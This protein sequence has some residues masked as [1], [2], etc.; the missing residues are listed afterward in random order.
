MRSRLCFASLIAGAA[1]VGLLPQQACG[2]GSEFMLAKLIVQ[3]GVV[4]L[5]IT[6]DYGENPMLSGEEDARES[7]QHL[8]LARAGGD[9]FRSVSEL[10]PLKFEHRDQLDPDI[11]LPA[12]PTA[13]DKPHRLLTSM[14]EWSPPSPDITLQV[15]ERTIHN[16]LLWTAPDGS[17]DNQAHWTVLTGG[18]RSPVIDVP[19]SGRVWDWSRLAAGAEAPSLLLAGCLGVLAPGLW[20][21]RRRTRPRKGASEIGKTNARAAVGGQA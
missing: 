20:L 13:A 7:L 14:W 12:D 19:P 21:V 15:D 1:L 2:H 5:E 16:V 6:A 10:A 11:P 8:I 17:K 4:R 9:A 3:P 18:D